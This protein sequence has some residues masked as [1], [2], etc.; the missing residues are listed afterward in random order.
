MTRK[1]KM[2]LKNYIGKF[3]LTGVVLILIVVIVGFIYARIDMPLLD[4][5]AI[6]I[7]L[8]IIYAWIIFFSIRFV[9]SIREIIS[10]LLKYKIVI[11][12]PKGE[13][14]ENQKTT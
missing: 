11:V 12:I 6:F 14:N 4:F 8:G 10:I 1:D 2:E 9:D 5:M 13:D 7:F 3:F